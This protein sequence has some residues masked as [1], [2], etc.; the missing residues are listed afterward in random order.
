MLTTQTNRTEQAPF[1]ARSIAFVHP[2]SGN[3]DVTTVAL[4]PEM[5][6]PALTFSISK[7]NR[8]DFELCLFI[9]VKPH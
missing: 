6:S 2:D 9:K 5:L 7:Q 3:I 8:E 1:R 4:V